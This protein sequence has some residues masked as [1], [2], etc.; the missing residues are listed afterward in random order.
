MLRIIRARSKVM[1]MVI[2]HMIKMSYIG[3]GY[4]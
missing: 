1:V 3:C 2:D 4:C